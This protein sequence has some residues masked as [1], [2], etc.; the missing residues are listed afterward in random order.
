MDFHVITIP[1]SSAMT[2]NFFGQRD[3]LH[4]N[5][6]GT[7]PFTIR[8]ARHLRTGFARAFNV[9]RRTSTRLG[10]FFGFKF[11]IESPAKA[12]VSGIGMVVQVPDHRVTKPQRWPTLT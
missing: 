6:S 2:S 12:A 11:R 3:N 1:F 9:A 7:S 10:T 8:H 4:S 5:P